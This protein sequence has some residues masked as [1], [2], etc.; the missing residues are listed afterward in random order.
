MQCIGGGGR[1]GLVKNYSEQHHGRRLHTQRRD[2]GKERDREI[3]RGQSEEEEEEAVRAGK[4]PFIG[5]P[6]I[7]RNTQLQSCSLKEKVQKSDD[8]KGCI[9][10]MQISSSMLQVRN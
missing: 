10:H 7:L 3:E 5:R 2:R 6:Q 8:G 4:V 9:N 1:G